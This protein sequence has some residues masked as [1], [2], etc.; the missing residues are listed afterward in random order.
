[1]NVFSHSKL[2]KKSNQMRKNCVLTQS[3]FPFLFFSFALFFSACKSERDAKEMSADAYAYIYAHTSGSIAKT[4][5]VRI[6]LNQAPKDEIEVG[7]E[8]PANCLRFSPR[9]EGKAIW[10]NLQTIRFE[11]TTTWRSGQKYV[12]YLQ[13]DQLFKDVPSS[14]ADVEFD[15]RIIELYMNV[16]LKSLRA[17]S[18]SNLEKQELEGLITTSDI[19]D[20]EAIEQTISAKQLNRDLPIKWEHSTN[21]RKHTFFI[22]DVRRNSDKDGEV[23]VEWDGKKVDIA[24]NGTEKYTIP[25]L[26]NFKLMEA[27]VVQGKDQ[28]IQLYF[29]DPL[30]KNQ[31][32]DGLISLQN[33]SGNLRY[34]I[35]GNEVRVYPS[36]RLVGQLK[37]DIRTGIKNSQNVKIRDPSSWDLQ[38]ADIKPQVRL[39]GNGVIM[40]NSDG[41]I[42]PF[43]AV[44]LHSVDVEIFKIFNNNILQYLQSNELDG[45]YDLKS[46]GRIE[47]QERISLKGLDPDAHFHQWRRYAIDLSKLIDTDPEAIYQIRIGFRPSYSTYFCEEQE[48]SNRNVADDEYYD[49][50]FYGE[51]RFSD[52]KDDIES[53]WGDYYG[54]EGYYDGYNWKQR[55]DPCFPAYYNYDNFIRRNVIA[56]DLGLIAKKGND[57]SIYVAVSDLRTTK[58]LANTQLSFYDYQQQLLKEVTT[59][60][61]GTINTTLERTPFVLI[62]KKGLQKGYLKMGDGNSLSLSKFD[63]AG[64]K[65]KEG[66]KGFIYGERGVWRPGD[67]IHLN[68]ILEDKANKLPSNYPITFEFSDPR[69]QVQIKRTTSEN[70]NGIYPLAVS[71]S[72]DDPTGNWLAKI[73]AGGASFSK[74]IKVETIKPNRLKVALDFGEEDL[75]AGTD[76]IEGDLQ[77]NWLHGAPAKS[78]RTKVEMQ[79]KPITTKFEGFSQY[80]FDDPTRTT[81][82]NEPQVIF[83][84]E[85]DAKGQGK[86][87]AKITNVSNVAGMM[88][89]DMKTR[90]FEK[91]G[92]FSTGLSSKKFHPYLSYTG[93]I[94]PKNKYNQKRVEIDVP[95]SVSFIALNDRGEIL[96]N[97]E[98][99][100]GLYRVQ[101]RWWWDRNNRNQTRFNSTDHTGAMQT[102]K[103]YTDNTGK[104]DWNFEID[105]WGRYLIRIC[106]DE[107]GH[108][109]GDYFYAGYPWYDEDNTNREGASI[110]AFSSNKTKYEVGEQ[111]ELNIPTGEDGRVLISIESGNKV[112][113]SY[114]MDAKKGDNTFR[115]YATEKMSPTVYANVSLLQ[116]HAQIKNDLPIRM[117]GVIPINVEDPKTK[118][119]PI[120]KMPEELQPEQ[121]V[122]IEVAEKSGTDMAYTIAMVDDGLLDLTNFKTPNPWDNFYKREALGV[123]TWDIYDHVLGAYGGELERVLSIGGDGE[124]A[125][126][127]DSQSANR[128]KPVVKH[129]GPFYLKKGQTAQH[130]ITVPN[131]VGSVRTMVVAADKGAYG[132]AEKTTPVRKPL[133]I[134]TTLPRVLGPS[135]NLRIPVTVFAMDKKIR[136][137]KVEMEEESGLINFISGKTQNLRFNGMGDQIAYFDVQVQDQIGIAKF[138]INASGH[139]ESAYEEIEIQIRNPNPYVTNVLSDVIKENE[140]WAIDFQ[141]AGMKGTNEGI[142][143]ISNLPPLNLGK[144]LE[145][146]I[147]YPHGCLEQTTSKGFPLLYLNRVVA[148]NDQQKEEVPKIIQATA[149]RLKR[150]QQ[151]DGGFSYWPSGTSR[152][153]WA[154]NYAGHF[155]VEAKNLGYQIPDL[156]LEKWIKYQQKIARKWD[157]EQNQ[158]GFYRYNSDLEQAYRLYVLAL[159]QA[160]DYGAM[161][162]M[163][164]M[165]NLRNTAKWRLAAT[166]AVVG[167]TEVARVLI[168]GVD[169]N[170]EA[171]KELSYTFGS[172][173]RDRAMILETL[174]L[175][176]EEESAFKLFEAI[177]EQ[178]STNN[179]YSTQTLAY[180]IIAAGKLIGEG[181]LSKEFSFAYQIGNGKVVNMGADKP[182]IQIEIGVDSDPSRA[183]K[184]SNT[185]NGN[186]FAR[187]ILTGQPVIG[188][189]T[190]ASNDLNMEV[191]YLD[192]KGKAINPDNLEQGTDFIAEVS[193]N[194]PGARG[195]DYKEMALTHIFPS[196]WEIINTR[197]DN[198]E[199]DVNNTAINQFVYQDI[200]D[201]RMDTFFNVRQNK[202]RIYRVRLNAAYQG[203]FYRP[204]IQCEAM[205]DHTINARQPGGW[206]NVSAPE[207]L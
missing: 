25:A 72:S 19:V 176:G 104:G 164:E 52:A 142:L 102:E 137:V 101:W 80:R 5:A 162:R 16:K 152:N 14:T 21:H 122:Q 51:D 168:D 17:E 96:K 187:L 172:D 169:T 132:I 133:M 183:I 7:A 56:S 82:A 140:D 12:A 37:L 42:F 144:R 49:D 154:T 97:K 61:E 182:V 50:E 110:L 2:T 153:D 36:N 174:S 77:V 15:F 129:L 67:S 166:Y 68:F 161:N 192:M 205:Y 206:V 127:S 134:L 11:P 149:D 160:P 35:D 194:N 13:L 24:Q 3:L 55:E 31:N 58:P 78:L 88:R 71:T 84:Q 43:E 159:A 190:A 18:A 113:E 30:L 23:I 180:C 112:V 189:Q 111:V 188:D 123:K 167:K 170:V 75:R 165:K 29:S 94:M 26:N 90:A 120:I 63:V 74:V 69:G 27:D 191:A 119:Q 196:G 124:A 147:R 141:A 106:D 6:R 89:L 59:D 158:A 95:S 99:T 53:I 151:A 8:L 114:W 47:H 178:I 204:T 83:D 98:L 115:F 150:F 128:F 146:L 92:D 126:P 20:D 145:Y 103:V 87:K 186:L 93:I 139:G 181:D 117:Y 199:T 60:S 48:A 86:V 202:Q 173:L 175:L 41:L 85:L 179:W 125:A 108:C 193:L 195:I 203:K 197:M 62:A 198:L 184:V 163:R 70:V 44:S 4:E 54:I 121:K 65:I 81:I 32:L 10:E 38:F 9:I 131:Y 100:V 156:M 39:V 45:S 157:P 46:V 118:L 143:E 107:S 177:S 28:Y 171:Y 57:G 76:G 155:L 130:E 34:T 91:G 109:T 79:L 207:N 40:P 135:E 148:L 138:K 1:M 116:P 105:N 73:K 201:D 33:Y 64:A 66:L 185:S 200:K 22:S 136:D